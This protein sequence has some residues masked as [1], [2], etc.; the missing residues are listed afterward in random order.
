M[1]TSADTPA[2]PP[3]FTPGEAA[4]ALRVTP[5]TIYLWIRSGK[6]RAI[7]VSERVTRVPA[8]EIERLLCADGGA[9]PATRTSVDT[10]SSLPD[11]SSVLWD[12]DSAHVDL[13]AHAR[14]I[15]GRILEAGRPA[16]VRWLFQRYPIELVLDVAENSRGLSHRASVAWSTLLRDRLNHV[17]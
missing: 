9:A 11:Q 15:I 17:A 1:V 6:L 2:A 8:A 12:M 7:H 3:L 5:R 16:Q 10:D 4:R 14:L 13:D